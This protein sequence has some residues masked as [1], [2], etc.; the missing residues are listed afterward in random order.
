MKG[1]RL[2]DLSSFIRTTDPSEIMLDF[3]IYG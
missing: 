1:I 2:R 3:P